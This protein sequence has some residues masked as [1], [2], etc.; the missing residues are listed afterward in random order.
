MVPAETRLECAV[1]KAVA[2]R[3]VMQR[4][5]Q[6]ALR[7]D[8]RVV[9]AELA[10]ALLARAPDGLDPQFRSLFDAAP[11][12]TARM[13]AVIDQIAALTDI[14]ARSLHARLTRKPGHTKANRR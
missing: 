7:A 11:D 5:D 3:Y 2:D 6:E 10:E 12:D 9:I 4:P 1:L 8:Q 14:S 13:R